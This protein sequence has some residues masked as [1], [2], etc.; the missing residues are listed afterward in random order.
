M[1]IALFG[2]TFDPIHRGHLAVA[3]AA[4]RRFHL[5]QVHFV[6]S[7]APPHKRAATHASFLHRYTMV[8]LATAGELR[9]VP[10]LLEAPA[11]AHRGDAEARSTAKAGP[12]YSV[13]TVRRFKAGLRR[14][15]RL[16]FLI[17]MDAFSEIATWRRPAALLQECDFI[18]VSRPGHSLEEAAEALPRDAA[19]WGLEH[20]AGRGRIVL[21]STAIHLMSG[22]E[23]AASATAVRAAAAAGKPLG[24]MVGPE[25]AEY[26]RKMHLYD[27]GGRQ[28][29]T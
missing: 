4:V 18:V 10:S 7:W 27:P 11:A 21:R 15:D 19:P 9:Y 29:G 20:T 16:Y 28:R 5:H 2:G 25:V 23:E 8:A 14:S 22:V 26:I 12:S 17:G 24:R 13:E 6:P 3:R 1:N